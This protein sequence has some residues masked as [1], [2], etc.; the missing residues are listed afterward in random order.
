MKKILGLISAI[1]AILLG[2]YFAM[3]WLTERTLKKTVNLVNQ[4]NEF[5]VEFTQYN[6]GWFK[7]LATIKWRLRIPAR[8]TKNNQYQLGTIPSKD[9]NGS[10][11]IEISHG[12]IIYNNSKVLFGF[13]EANIHFT[14]PKEYENYFNKIYSNKSTKPVLDLNVF[15]YD[16]FL[17]F[18]GK[19]FS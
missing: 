6:R 18:L 2:S 8:I 5:F 13:G 17:H 9:Y 4:S 10:L 16:L 7:S 19:F 14:L 15:S 3:G 11:P 1:V 12:P